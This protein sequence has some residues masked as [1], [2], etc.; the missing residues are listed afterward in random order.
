MSNLEPSIKIGAQVGPNTTLVQ[1]CN[2]HR[3]PMGKIAYLFTNPWMADFYGK[4]SSD[5][6][7]TNVPYILPFATSMILEEAESK[8]NP[9]NKKNF[10]PLPYK[11]LP[12]HHM[13]FPRVLEAIYKTS[14]KILDGRK[15]LSHPKKNGSQVPPHSP[16]K[17]SHIKPRC[18]QWNRH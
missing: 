10:S 13:F 3:I 7:C 11:V 12:C 4:V 8:L 14:K 18:C 9:P 15:F 1:K 5:S 6:R 16:V 17:R 2:T